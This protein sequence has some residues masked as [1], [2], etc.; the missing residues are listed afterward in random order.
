MLAA[1]PQ[2]IFSWEFKMWRRRVVYSH[3][4]EEKGTIRFSD[5]AVD[6][7][8]RRLAIGSDV[9]DSFIRVFNLENSEEVDLVG[10][11]EPIGVNTTLFSEDGALLFTGGKDSCVNVW[12]VDEFK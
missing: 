8:K 2:V 9:G 4:H 6:W 1:G 3:N 12:D 10:H 7:K 5:M 11:K